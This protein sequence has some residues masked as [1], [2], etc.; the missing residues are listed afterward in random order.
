MRLALVLML[1]ALAFVLGCA[2]PGDPEP[3]AVTGSGSTV[4]TGP[5]PGGIRLVAVARGLD[6]PVH[7]AAAPGEPDRLYVVE[8]A[9]RIRI[10]QGGRVQAKPFLDVTTEVVSGGEQGLLS[11]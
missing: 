8:Q 1:A 7:V 11:I 6:N 4:E 9:G 10:V 2:G 3:R 5:S